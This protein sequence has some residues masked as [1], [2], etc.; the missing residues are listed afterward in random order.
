MYPI[1]GN[2]QAIG[3]DYMKN[4][5]QKGAV[6]KAIKT[7]KTVIAG[8]VE[9][10][11]GG[12]GFIA[13]IPVY[14]GKNKTDYW[15]LASIVVDEIKLY[16]QI[17]ILHSWHWLKYALKGKD[18]KGMDGEIFFGDKSIFENNPVIFNIFLPEGSWV[19]AA[20]PKQGWNNVKLSNIIYF[21][22]AGYSIALI[23]CRF[24]I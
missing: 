16:D 23:C 24:I 10:I 22:T 13:R 11:Q 12:R 1:K 6:I 5:K 17:R 8:P 4:E 3:L 18:A 15:G 2:E 9:L 7:G 20:Y 21:R 19:L 14:K